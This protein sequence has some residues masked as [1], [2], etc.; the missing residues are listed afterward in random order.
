MS[1]DEGTGGVPEI[2]APSLHR[3]GASEFQVADTT[4]SRRKTMALSTPR[5][6]VLLDLFCS[7]LQPSPAL[8][9]PPSSLLPSLPTAESP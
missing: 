3:T 7:C 1:T 2:A 6:P 9:P 4:S 5:A 8:E